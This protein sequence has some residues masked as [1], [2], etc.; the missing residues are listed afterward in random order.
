MLQEPLNKIDPEEAILAWF[1]FYAF[2]LKIIGV[3]MN[4]L[5]KCLHELIP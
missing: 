1:L 5:A 3:L 2:T 4:L